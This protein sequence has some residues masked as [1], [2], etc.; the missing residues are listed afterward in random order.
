[1]N[2]IS[3]FLE[4]LFVEKTL[5]IKWLIY[6]FIRALWTVYH[7]LFIQYL[8]SA[9]ENNDKENFI[10]VIIIYAIFNVLYDLVF[11]A[12]RNWW[13]VII[14][15]SYRKFIHRKCLNKFVSLWNTQT[16]KIWTWKLISVIDRWMDEWSMLLDQV[17]LNWMLVIMAFFFSLYMVVRV[18]ISYWIVFLGV[19]ITLHIVWAYIN[20]F[21][22]IERWRRQDYWIL[23][24]KHI[25][26]IIMSKY[27]ILQTSKI[28]YEL[29]KLDIIWNE[30]SNCSRRM[31]KY[32][33][34]FFRIPE[35]IIA[36]SK[37][38]ILLYL[39]FEIFE[40]NSS[41]A[42]F[43]WV[44]WVFT[45]LDS[46]ISKSMNF[47]KDFT[48]KFI[49][50]EKLWDFLDNTPEIQWYNNW[51]EFNYISWNIE[52]KNIS[53]SY[54][55][56]K[57]VFENFDLNIAWWKITAF[58]WNSWWWKTTLVKI[59]SQYIRQDSWKVII[60]WQNL[61]K[62]SLKSYYKNIWYLTQD[63]SVF[64][65]TIFD[66][67]TYALENKDTENFKSQL[68]DKI[69]EIIKLSKCEF[70][71][72]YKD[73]LE[74]EIWERWVR[75]SWWQR[76]RLAIA[77]IML[78]DPRIIILD[79]PT[80]ALDSFSEELITKAMN[81]LFKWRTVLVIAH[82]LQTVK[83]A[84]EIIVIENWKIVERWTHKELVS[85]KWT[86]KK[87]LDLQSGF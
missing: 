60:D 22:I 45:V 43:V 57:N 26:K 46:A 73:W 28:W 62:I 29:D 13:W 77:K 4:P 50:V 78:K 47:F 5:T 39:W 16:E 37:F 55:E 33:H 2:K 51:K 21:T 41:F 12:V 30:L 31:N 68:N 11:Y 63:P 38:A 9:I 8:V 3:R 76:Q 15:N 54:S 18:N 10:K 35:W 34:L 67:L 42:I 71:Y 79:E 58:V 59:I 87:M 1:M 40:W 72:D 24:T 25:V 52:L 65:W 66:N 69:D 23:Y 83:H 61:E 86:Y 49:V 53:F 36:W 81:N 80:S 70:I 17:M 82:R 20:S 48:Y 19:Y 85:I 6:Y 44:F 74:T 84:N 56:N 27:E 14:V 64:D 75:L 7:V 32:V